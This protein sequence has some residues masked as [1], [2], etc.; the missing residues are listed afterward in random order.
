MYHLLHETNADYLAHRLYF[1]LVDNVSEHLQRKE[2]SAAL[3]A[4]RIV[5]PLFDRCFLRRNL[6]SIKAPAWQKALLRFYLG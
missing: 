6:K 1:F 4:L 2:Y 5:R 3:H